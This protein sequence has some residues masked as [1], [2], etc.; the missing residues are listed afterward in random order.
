VYKEKTCLTCKKIFIPTTGNALYCGSQIKKTGCSHLESIRWKKECNRQGREYRKLNPTIRYCEICG[1][2]IERFQV[3]YCKECAKKRFK[4]IS[5]KKRI[6]KKQRRLKIRFLI[7]ERDNF[8]CQYC[9]RKA[10]EVI[11]E[12]D[13]KYPKKHGGLDNEKNYITACKDCN[14]GKRDY[15]LNEFKK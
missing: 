14:T 5:E 9:G 11:L 12:V 7:L 3:Y 13:H 8:T 1:K 10:P 2:I 4:K 15:I 6:I